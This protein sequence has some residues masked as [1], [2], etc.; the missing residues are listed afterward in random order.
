[1]SVIRTK[2]L[3]HSVAAIAIPVAL[4][5][6]LQSSFS[7]VD[8][9]MAGQLGSTSIA[10]IGIAGKF[11]FMYSTAIGA[12]AAI[13]G[14]MISQYEGQGDRSSSDRSLCT[15]LG[16]VLLLGLLFTLVSLVAP[17]RITSLYSSDEAA[18]EAAAI[19]LRIL[20]GTY[21]PLGLTAILSVSLRCADDPQAPLWASVVSA[22][23]NTGL[24]YLLIFGHFGFPQL[25]LQGAAIATVCGCLAGAGMTLW[26]F[27]RSLHR[28]EVPFQFS[29]F[30]SQ[31]EHLAY[32]R[33]L[34]PLLVT[35]LLWS[36]G[37][38]VNTF[39]YGHI[40]TY[41]L[42]SVALISPV[43]SLLIGLLSGI[44]QAAGILIG[45][46]IGAEETK[47]AYQDS[48]SL[49]WSGLAG[50]L[51]LSVLLL[52]LRNLYTAIFNVEEE[53]KRTAAQLLLAF[54]VLAPFKVENMI[55]GGGILRSGGKTDI[56]MWIDLF[57]T[58]VLG[59][60]LGLLS[61]RVFHLPVVTVY[62]IIGL[63]E[64]VRCIIS[65][66]MFHRKTWMTKL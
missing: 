6:L 15:T 10:G 48:I 23:T 43:E 46:R 50:A 39:I 54:A 53:V 31:S 34:I 11:A 51:F 36:L 60:P 32:L 25:G 52:P 4:Q 3:I 49:M 9:I 29:L 57:G 61:A 65:I 56:V 12:I 66:V 42:A 19:Y 13:A 24:N 45:K 5:S 58:W 47:L 27:L 22:L 26:F 8:Q 62:F 28:R 38:N 16:S 18:I 59:V 37:Q 40:S 20:S 30:A 1:M 17:T 41:S 2:P 44:A 21:L 7:M 55:I 63:E 35:E 14:I 33:M 64:V